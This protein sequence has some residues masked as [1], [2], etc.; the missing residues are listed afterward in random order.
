MIFIF[1]ICQL[2]YHGQV[3]LERWL[4]ELFQVVL[5]YCFHLL[6][7]THIFGKTGDFSSRLISI[8]WLRY[9]EMFRTYDNHKGPEDKEISADPAG[10]F[11]GHL[12]LP[13]T[14]DFRDSKT[15]YSARTSVSIIAPT[16]DW[17]IIERVCLQHAPKMCLQQP[18]L[19]FLHLSP[20][21]LFSNL[22]S[23]SPPWHTQ[24]TTHT[25]P[26]FLP[27]SFSN[28]GCWERWF[29]LIPSGRNGKYILI[30][31]LNLIS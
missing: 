13:T 27:F 3:F 7:E 1:F 12:P 24:T 2:L 28:T 17:F 11:W 14:W 31:T 29:S 4:W 23:P 20:T 15:E 10:V 8:V 16:S 26:V 6:H 30:I 18:V 25:L 22:T 21:S 9:V 5:Q 19:L